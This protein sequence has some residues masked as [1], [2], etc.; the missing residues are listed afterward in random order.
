MARREDRLDSWKEI[1]A[2]LGRTTR[3]CQK[4][5]VDY[6]L[7]VHRLN[8]SPRSRVCAF[9]DELDDWFERT[10]HQIETGEPY[11]RRWWRRVQ[12]AWRRRR[13]VHRI[14]FAFSVTEPCTEAP[15]ISTSALANKA[16]WTGW[17]AKERFLAT[18]NP[19]DLG[20]AV[21]MFKKVLMEDPACPYAFLGLGDVYR[22][23]YSFQGMKPDRLEL[24]IRS[25]ERA[26]EIAPDL[27]ET[28]VGMGWI[29]YFA[30]DTAGACEF[31]NRAFQTKPA[32]PD[33]NLNIANFLIG[34][35]HPE[36]AARR[37]TT[38]LCSSPSRP[39]VRWLRALCYEW[40]GNYDAAMA[41]ARMAIDLEPTSGY[42]RCMLA[43]LKI[44]TGNLPE[45][46]A[47][48]SI[49]DTLSRGTGD[50]EFTRALLWAARGDRRRA[51]DA[52]ARPSRPTVLRNYIETMAHAA[53]GD[54]DEAV[55]LIDHTIEAGFQKLVSH[56]YF[57]LFLANPNN[58]FY[59]PLRHDPRFLGIVARQ[60][61]RYEQESVWLG[62]L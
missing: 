13:L 62:D 36:R 19:S 34:L 24:M 1:S 29:R 8:G 2:Y 37:F 10:L 59:D 12:R 47:E 5:E 30:I 27:A 41:D 4:W 11:Y 50:V 46:E 17:N 57:Y 61:R 14:S 56:P 32:D 16:Y 9:R 22:W 6:G 15:A 42:L 40:I 58:H 55:D 20:V 21:E 43:R 35:G 33:I 7:P 39:T 49:A 52:L 28:N 23:D 25:Y 31:F 54:R 51:E 60:K 26:H 45:A 18:R 53:L 38:V 44:F 48:L 3:T